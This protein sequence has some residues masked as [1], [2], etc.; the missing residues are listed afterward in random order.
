MLDQEAKTKNPTQAELGGEASPPSAASASAA[1]LALAAG[2]RWKTV[3]NGG[4]MLEKSTPKRA[5]KQTQTKR[6]KIYQSGH[7][8][9][10]SW[11]PEAPEATF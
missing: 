7:P 5:K 11:R 9:S 4:K 2:K 3:E 1:D 10:K 8:G 6:G